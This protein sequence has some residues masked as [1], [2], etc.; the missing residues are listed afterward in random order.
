MRRIVKDK[1]CVVISKR[2]VIH[3][4]MTN[5]GDGRW[6]LLSNEVIKNSKYL[7]TAFFWN[8]KMTMISNFFKKF[9]NKILKASEEQ[10]HREINFKLFLI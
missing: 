8:K 9:R 2:D 6:K 3:F 1:N 5:P 4:L 10:G 7:L